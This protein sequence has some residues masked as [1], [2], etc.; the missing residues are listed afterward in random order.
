MKDLEHLSGVAA[1]TIRVWERR[2]TV[3]IPQRTLTNIRYYNND[4]V[5]TILNVRLLNKNNYKI[6][7]IAAMSMEAR[8]KAIEDL[9]HPEAI[10]ENILDEFVLK[11]LSED[12]SFIEIFLN[13][14]MRDHGIDKSIKEL[15]IPLIEKINFLSESGN[16]TPWHT[17]FLFSKIRQILFTGITM[18]GNG[19]NGGAKV[20][21][22]LP[23]G[24][25]Y[26]L[27]LLCLGYLLKTIGFDP[28]ILSG[29]A[30]IDDLEYI[31]NSMKV[32]LLCTNITRPSKKLKVPEYEELLNSHFRTIPVIISGTYLHYGKHQKLQ[33]L[34]YLK[35]IRE[36]FLFINSL[37]IAG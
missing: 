26:D 37:M 11:I 35:T 28:V 12:G 21:L 14:Y 13:G 22:F 33:N 20:L 9:I 8:K 30:T 32:S 36:T 25:S 5:Q 17:H 3:L 18:I 19:E 27:G 10:Q 34:T 1:H 15:I 6:S 4:D 31:F 23:V 2:H 24:E 16:L 7:S 29:Q